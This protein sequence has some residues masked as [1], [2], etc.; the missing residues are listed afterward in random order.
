MRTI[1]PLAAN[2]LREHRWPVLL[3]FGWIILLALASADLGRPRALPDDVDF[4]LVQQAI[5]I[6]VFSAFL[7]ADA[8][9]NDRK[10]KRILLVLSKAITRGEY[11]LAPVLGTVAAAIA[12]SVFYWICSMWL[13]DRAALPATNLWAIALLAV[14]GSLVAATIA[15]FFSTFLNPYVAVAATVL[16]IAAPGAFHAQRHPWSAWLPGFPVLMQIVNF[17]PSSDWTLHWRTLLLTIPQAAA[18]WAMA[19]AVFN[20]RDIAVPVE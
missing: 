4:Y 9:N 18:F 6:S 7:A 8:I 15:L 17:K 13:T 5:F 14:G 1:F 3:L 12:Y 2:F 11:L 19:A 20:R 10:S 16:L